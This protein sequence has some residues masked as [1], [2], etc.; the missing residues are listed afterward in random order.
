MLAGRGGGE[1][2]KSSDNEKLGL[3]VIRV[4]FSRNPTHAY[5]SVIKEKNREKNADIVV[6]FSGLNKLKRQ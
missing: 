3:L 4:Q 2:K 1:V 5:F 6:I